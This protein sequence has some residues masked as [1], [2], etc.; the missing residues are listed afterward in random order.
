MREKSFLNATRGVIAEKPGQAFGQSNETGW[1]YT[2]G[3]VNSCA[4]SANHHQ[5]RQF[6]MLSGMDC[7]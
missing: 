4:F 3:I 5:H 7:R 1:F 6:A 2:M